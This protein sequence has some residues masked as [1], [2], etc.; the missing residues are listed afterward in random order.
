MEGH[1]SSY[2]ETY[3]LNGAEALGHSSTL[4]RQ[5]THVLVM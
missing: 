3:C 5:I 1:W 2:I 4:M